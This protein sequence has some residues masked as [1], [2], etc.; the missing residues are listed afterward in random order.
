M[1]EPDRDFKNG[2]RIKGFPNLF[3]NIK[4]LYILNEIS[5]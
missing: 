3:L 2:S 4:F 1:H 5:C